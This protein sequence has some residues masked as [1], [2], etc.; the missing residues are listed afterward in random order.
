LPT[1]PPASSTQERLLSARIAVDAFAAA[2]LPVPQQ[3]DAT[4]VR[5]RVAWQLVDL[6]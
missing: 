3:Q 2:N 5:L 1:V 6:R 4:R